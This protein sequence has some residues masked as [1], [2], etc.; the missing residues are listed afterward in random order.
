MRILKYGITLNRL[1][2]EDLETVRQ[3]RNSEVV[4]QYM[5]Y[6]EEITVEQHK[7]WF[8]SINNIYNFYFIIE[9]HG[10]KIGLIN[11][12]NVDWEKKCSEAG[13]FIWDEKYWETPIPILA[14]LLLAE[15]GFDF[16][17]HT[18]SYAEIVRTN[19]RAVNFIQSLGYFPVETPE[20]AG[21]QKFAL[22]KNSFDRAVAK[23]LPLISVFSE[24]P[25][26]KII[27]EKNDC[28]NGVAELILRLYHLLPV[29]EQKKFEITRDY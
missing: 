5:Q 3:G 4:K 22:D 28:E 14:S 25:N 23:I 24:N 27:L 13:I 7:N 10:K 15:G 2:E 17:K 21:A 12:K 6:R 26:A 18:R 16:F 20:T 19:E 8:R 1:K 9:H 29:D 11:S